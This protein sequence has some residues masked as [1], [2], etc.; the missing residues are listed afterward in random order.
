MIVPSFERTDGSKAVITVG[1]DGIDT[2]HEKKLKCNICGGTVMK[3][4]DTLHIILPFDINKVS[5]EDK[6]KDAG[7]LDSVECTNMTF[8]SIGKRVRCQTYYIL[9]RG[10]FEVKD[11]GQFSYAP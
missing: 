10:K 11:D 2:G 3:Y 6:F 1:L 7:A 8:N 9:L 5:D 4:R